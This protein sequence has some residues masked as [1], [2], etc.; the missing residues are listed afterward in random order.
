MLSRRIYNGRKQFAIT[1]MNMP[2]IWSS[3]VKRIHTTLKSMKYSANHSTFF[4]RNM[5]KKTANFTIKTTNYIKKQLILNNSVDITK[6]R[7]DNRYMYVF[8][9]ER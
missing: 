5:P 9:F 4:S 1:T 2:I 6:I 7:L 8:V 3:Y